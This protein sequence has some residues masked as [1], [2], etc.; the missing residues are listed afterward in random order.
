MKKTPAYIAA[1]VG[2]LV[3]LAMI[4]SYI[5]SLIPAFVAVPGFKIGL[6]NSVT[7]FALYYLGRRYALCISVV[8]VLLS[9][10]LFGSPVSLI[11]SISGALL[12]LMGMSLLRGVRIFSPIGVSTAGGVLHNIGQIAAAC[13]LLGSGAI[14]YLPALLIGGVI[15]G[16]VIGLIAGIVMSRVK[17]LDQN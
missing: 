9:A 16:V 3:A 17:S 12:S 10:L 1:L 13:F 5:E 11:Y 2:V 6:A 8:R 7:V 14:F 15:S 4:L